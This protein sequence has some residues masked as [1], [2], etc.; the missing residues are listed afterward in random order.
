[1]VSRKCSWTPLPRRQQRLAPTG[2]EVSA[3]VSSYCCCRGLPAGRCQPHYWC[4]RRRPGSRRARRQRRP[5]TPPPPSA[6]TTCPPAPSRC[7]R[8]THAPARDEQRRHLL[9]MA[10]STNRQQPSP[11]KKCARCDARSDAVGRRGSLR[12]LVAAMMSPGSP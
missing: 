10:L 9:I 7:S 2:A 5:R 6:S 12:C 4:P 11:R 8:S 1:M 3:T